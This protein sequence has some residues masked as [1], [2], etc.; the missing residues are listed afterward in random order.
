MRKLIKDDMFSERTNQRAVFGEE[1]LAMERTNQRLRNQ[2]S[3][4]N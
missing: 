3:D 1:E 4:E 2:I